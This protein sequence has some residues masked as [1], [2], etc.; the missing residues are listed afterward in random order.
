LL[1]HAAPARAGQKRHLPLA[2]VTE[3]GHPENED[4]VVNTNLF[5]DDILVAFG[6]SS[7]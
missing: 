4:L 6:A 3:F 5:L 7:G 2:Y 1:L